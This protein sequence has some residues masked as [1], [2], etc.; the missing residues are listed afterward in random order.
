MSE[1]F[2]FVKTQWH[3]IKGNAKWD[4][5]KWGAI[6]VIISPAAIIRFFGHAPLWQ[7]LVVLVASTIC[8]AVLF[9]V[10]LWAIQ[11]WGTAKSIT[12][13]NVHGRFEPELPDTKKPAENRR[14]TDLS[15]KQ[16]SDAIEAVPPLQRASIHESFIGVYVSWRG[17]LFTASRRGDET[18]VS[19]N[20][21]SQG[22]G[23][24]HCVAA[25]HDCEALLIVPEGTEL[26]VK[27]KGRWNNSSMNTI[28]NIRQPIKNG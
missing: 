2:N 19:L 18:E 7:V 27:G 4:F 20:D 3:D 1:F 17:K 9:C 10:I 16:I 13:R 26:I 22:G 21:V 6:A 15:H 14:I 24:V 28:Q 8:V 25:S 12:R 23:L 11:K 5:I